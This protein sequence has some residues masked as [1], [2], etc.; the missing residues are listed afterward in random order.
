MAIGFF[1]N[2]PWTTASSTLTI[3]AT[4]SPALSISQ[5]ANPTTTTRAGTKITIT[6]KVTNTGNV[7]LSPVTITDSLTGL[8]KITCPQSWLAVGATETCTATY[9]TTQSDVTRGSITETATATA[10]SPHGTKVTASSPLT[11]RT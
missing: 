3:N 11:I 7:T 5:S 1:H 4:Q 6:A 10:L 2:W 9:V 8:S